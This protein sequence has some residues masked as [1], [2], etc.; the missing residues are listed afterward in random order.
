MYAALFL[1]SIGQALL[2]LNWVAGP[3][4]LVSFGILFALRIRAEER[5]MLETFGGST[6]RTWLGP[7]ASYPASGD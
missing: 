4:H 6:R 3:S 7:S 2:L 5:M 1:Y